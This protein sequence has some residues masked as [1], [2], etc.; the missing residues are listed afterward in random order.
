M[1]AMR[2]VSSQQLS[3]KS[4]LKGHGFSR[5]NAEP[6]ELALYAIHYDS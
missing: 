6:I 2:V 3:H 5:A 1:I 4:V